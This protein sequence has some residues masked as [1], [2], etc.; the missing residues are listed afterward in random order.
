MLNDLHNHLSKWQTKQDQKKKKS[1][2]KN[3]IPSNRK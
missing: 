2:Q 3:E 1:S